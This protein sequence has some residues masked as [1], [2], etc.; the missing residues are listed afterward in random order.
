MTEARKLAEHHL[1]KYVCSTSQTRALASML[2]VAL[3][4]LEKVEDPRKRDH[5]EPDDYMVSACLMHIAH[6]A[7][8]EIEAIAKGEK[9]SVVSGVT[10][11]KDEHVV[12]VG[13]KFC[14][15]CGKPMG[16]K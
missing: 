13:V 12:C 10:E 14:D 15:K 4:A 6:T 3:G 16:K 7:K 2:L 8:V 1:D 11:Y 5:A 9:F